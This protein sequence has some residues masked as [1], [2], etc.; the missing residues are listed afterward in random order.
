MKTLRNTSIIVAV[1]TL[2]LL[3]AVPA[4]YATTISQT[5]VYGPAPTNYGVNGSLL[6]NNSVDLGPISLFDTN[7]G[8]LNSVTIQFSGEII[9]T[10]Q[11]TNNDPVPTDPPSNVTGHDTGILTLT[12]SNA[13]LTALFA[14]P[15]NVS[16]GNASDLLA[17]GA[18]G[19]AHPVSGSAATSFLAVN[20]VDFSIFEAVGG[21]SLDDLFYIAAVGSSTVSADNGD[22]SAKYVTNGAGAVTID[23][24]YGGTPP[25]PEP[26]TL[27]LF[28]TG[29]LGL[30]GML[31]S[32]FSKVR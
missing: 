23:Y 21:G 27:S 10:I 8:V 15:L 32:R 31:R 28:G 26:G 22:G 19:P 13:D 20:P 11:F 2:A 9:G 5:V 16:T 4:A 25:V 30:A 6:P 3:V 7:L 18:T 24:N 12:S 1:V 14:T 29:L 17:S